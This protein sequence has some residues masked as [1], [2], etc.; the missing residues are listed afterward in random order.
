MHSFLPSFLAFVTFASFSR[1]QQNITVNSTSPDIKYQGNPASVP[2]CNI[3]PN[4][5]FPAG[6]AGCY[7]V[8][9]HCSDTAFVGQGGTGVATFSFNGSAIYITG[10]L[11]SL[12]PLYT[13]TLD[14]TSTDVDGVVSSPPFICAPLY[15]KTGL[16]P[17]VEHQISLSVK[18]PSPNRN[19]SITDSEDAY[20]FGLV[21]FVYTEGGANG[22]Q[23]SAGTTKANAT[24]QTSSPK[25]SS[26]AEGLQLNWTIAIGA[27]AVILKLHRL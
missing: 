18:G 24:T 9:S 7:N 27:I 15:S 3:F 6:Q 13:V 14:G 22:S 21:N 17:N 2:F 26:G 23:L 12:S 4:G 19:Q 25:S 16:D 8:P 5:T 10:L 1:A 11:D 20:V